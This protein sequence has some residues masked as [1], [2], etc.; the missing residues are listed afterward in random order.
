AEH[1]FALLLGRALQLT[2][3]LRDIGEDAADGR[4]YVPRTHL[5]AAG[6]DGEEP[7]AVI[8]HPRFADAARRLAAD[9]AR[10]FAAAGE[11]VARGRGRP[12]WPALAMMGAYRPVLGRLD[13]TGYSPAIRVRPSRRAALWA[14]FRAAFVPF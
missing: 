8:R 13:R 12:L 9:A 4:L 1:E 10:A 6:I 11:R 3:I 14:A 5:A 2:N 7:Q